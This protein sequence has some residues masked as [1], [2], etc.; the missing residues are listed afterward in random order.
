MA[1]KRV[2]YWLVQ[3]SGWSLYFLISI[4]LLQSSGI[5]TYTLNLY[6]FGVS[7]ILVAIVLS[8]GIRFVIIKRN[9]LS[10]SIPRLIFVTLILCVSAGVLLEF[11]QDFLTENVIEVDFYDVPITEIHEKF[12]WADFLLAV[13]RSIILFLLWSGFYYLFAIVEKSRAQEILNLKWQASK[14]EIEL[15]NLRAQLNPH[16]LFNSLNSIRALVDLDPNQA[17]TSITHLSKLLR[18]SLMYGKQ[19][20]ISLKEELELVNIY[21]DLEKIR[22]EER[23]LIEYDIDPDS[24]DLQIPPLL[25]QTIVENGIKHGIA[26]SVEGGVLKVSTSLNNKELSVVI[27]NSGEYQPIEGNGVGIENSR[28]RLVILYGGNATFD[29]REKDGVVQVNINIKY[30]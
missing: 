30:T 1:R 5:F 24:L 27:E 6:V 3:I 9:L 29:I 4:L 17:K 22:F 25:L 23:L 16:F 8:H 10:R 18:Q 19:K 14:N 26:K 20:M 28:K 15:K 12:R 21:L 7:S 13:S 11:F 2:L